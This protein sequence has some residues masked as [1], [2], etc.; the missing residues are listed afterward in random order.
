MEALDKHYFDLYREATVSDLEIEVMHAKTR[1][2]GHVCRRPNS[3]SVKQALFGRFL[4]DFQNKNPSSISN[5]LPVSESKDLEHIWLFDAR[6]LGSKVGQPC[7]IMENLIS[8]L[9]TYCGIPIRAIPFIVRKEYL[10]PSSDPNSKNK[11]YLFYVLCREAYLRCTR[12]FWLGLDWK[13]FNDPNWKG[14]ASGDDREL[15]VKNA[16]TR[17]RE[18]Q[19]CSISWLDDTMGFLCRKHGINNNNLNTKDKVFRSGYCFIC[20]SAFFIPGRM[21]NEEKLN[22]HIEKEH[23]H[24]DAVNN[25]DRFCTQI[26]QKY[27]EMTLDW[28]KNNQDFFIKDVRA[29]VDILSEDRFFCHYCSLTFSTSPEAMSKHIHDHKEDRYMKLARIQPNNKHAGLWRPEWHEFNAQ[30]HRWE[31]G[32]GAL[33]EKFFTPPGCL[34]DGKI[35]CR[36]C[37]KESKEFSTAGVSDEARAKRINFMREHEKLCDGSYQGK[38]KDLRSRK[39]SK[40]KK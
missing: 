20:D 38:D 3:D 35:V 12:T 7:T 24:P 4:P 9:T 21:S 29:D 33:Y 32:P 34:V 36:K 13:K 40:S 16:S 26:H 23:L 6:D 17:L 10:C 5:F 8:W 37:K 18:K 28:K 1:F 27:E 31:H 19:K 39:F 2:F 15:L 11:I 25:Q 22:L 30:S 14:P